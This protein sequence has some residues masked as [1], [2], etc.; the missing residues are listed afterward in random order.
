M[1]S[2]CG[3]LWPTNGEFGAPSK[4]QWVLRLGFVIAL[5]SLNGGQPNFA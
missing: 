3:E 4:F 1:S 2:Q 5:T